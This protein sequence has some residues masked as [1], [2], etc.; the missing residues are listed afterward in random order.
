LTLSLNGAPQLVDE[1]E[2]AAMPDAVANVAG[3]YAAL[4]DDIAEGTFT[5]AGFDHAV[6]LTQLV[7]DL[8]EASR[9]GSRTQAVNWPEQ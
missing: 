8:L 5:V 4:R 6:K 2:L 7:S 1:G 9:A 3:V